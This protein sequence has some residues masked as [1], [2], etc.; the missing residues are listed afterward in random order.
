[1]GSNT[2]ENPWFQLDRDS[3]EAHTNENIYYPSRRDLE[4]L[5]AILAGLPWIWIS[6]DAYLGFGHI[7]GYCGYPFQSR[8]IFQNSA[9]SNP[10][11]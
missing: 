4:C 2:L 6:M 10:R 11:I 7:H 1:M 5:S 3:Q 9:L 8:K